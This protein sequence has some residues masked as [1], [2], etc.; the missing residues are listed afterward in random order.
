MLF[1]S[2]V[3][4]SRLSFFPAIRKP[5]SNSIFSNKILYGEMPFSFK[6]LP[7]AGAPLDPGGAEIKEAIIYPFLFFPLP[8]LSGARPFVL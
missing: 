8:A 5:L 1:P 4:A 2:P 3:H 7:Y 6:R